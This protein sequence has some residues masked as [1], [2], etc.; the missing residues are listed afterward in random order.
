M[1]LTSMTSHALGELGDR[2]RTLA[3]E[4][5]AIENVTSYQNPTSYLP[6]LPEKQF[7]LT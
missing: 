3:D 2:E 7:G 4:M 5:A 6:Q 1:H